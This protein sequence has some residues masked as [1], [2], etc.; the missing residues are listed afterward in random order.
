MHLLLKEERNGRLRGIRLCKG[1]RM[2]NHFLFADDL[3]FFLAKATVREAENLD[4]CLNSIWD[5]RSKSSTHFSKNFQ[6]PPAR[7]IMDTLNLKHLP[8]KA[9]HLGLPLLIPR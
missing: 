2:I 9:R 6:G 3:F 1:A 8:P 5:G 4:A 7:H